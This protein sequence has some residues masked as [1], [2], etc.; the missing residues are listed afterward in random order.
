M[1]K[2]IYLGDLFAIYG[3]LF[4][5][6][7]QACFQDYYFHNL[8]LSEMSENYGVTRN[9]IH[10]KLKE[11]EEKLLFYENTLHIYEKNK[12]ILS[13]IQEKELKEKIEEIL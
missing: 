3:D 6:K 9:A 7:Q 11:T 1:E 5:E 8:T 2:Q 4:T 10:K 13:L 12:K